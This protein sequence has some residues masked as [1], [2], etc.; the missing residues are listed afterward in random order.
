MILATNRNIKKLKIFLLNKQMKNEKIKFCTNCL[1]MSTRPRITFNKDSLCNA[2]VWVDKKK[3]LIGI[4]EKLN[5]NNYYLILEKK[6][7]LIALYL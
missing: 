4:K 1:A 7:I 5:W 6:M 2:C 3:K